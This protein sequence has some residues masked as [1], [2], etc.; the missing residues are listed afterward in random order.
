MKVVLQ[1]VKE[2]SVSVGGAQKSS[3]GKGFLLLVGIGRTDKLDVV[4]KMARKISKM[5]IFEDENGKMNLDLIQA[6]GEILSVP[7]FTLLADTRKGNRPG[8]DDA[9][10]PGE[11]EAL[12]KMF[13]HSLRDENVSVKEGEFGAHMEINLINDGPVTIILEL[14]AGGGK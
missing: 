6:G 1:R 5:R 13:N 9:A 8:F 11:A 3:I 14:N 4:K 12:W 10:D 2:A 7:Q